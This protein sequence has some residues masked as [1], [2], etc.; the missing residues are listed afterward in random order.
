MCFHFLNPSAQNDDE[1]SLCRRLVA[2]RSP[3]PACN[4]YAI[5]LAVVLS[6]TLAT[7]RAPAAAFQ[8]TTT[9]VQVVTQAISSLKW[10]PPAAIPFGTALGPDQ[11]NAIAGPHGTFAYSPP[12][13][14]LLPAGTQTLSVIFTPDNPGYTIAT[15]SVPIV[16]TPPGS[17]SFSVGTS[18]PLPDG[19]VVLLPNQPST[20]GLNIV[21]LGDFHQPVTLTC[22]NP[23]ALVSCVF[24]PAVVR[25][26]TAP[27]RVA[28]TLEMNQH[29][30][31]VRR[32]SDLG[33]FVGDDR[34][35]VG[36]GST[37][38]PSV[39]SPFTSPQIQGAALLALVAFHRR[40]AAS[41]GALSPLL[42]IGVLFSLCIWALGC[43][44]HFNSNN[45]TTLTIVASSLTES[46]SVSM[47]LNI[48]K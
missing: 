47:Q 42:A 22:R 6:F 5:I 39:P 31:A 34:F 29:P 38:Q 10:S 23:P 12:S 2:R 32:G 25:P 13:G 8:D 26:T 3:G 24:S 44:F 18:S 46:R 43:G 35:S 14:A 28:L 17:S 15:L 19:E 41:L 27:V 1:H 48:V 9:Y 30:V 37:R 20:V 45:Q 21:P 4:R 11:L 7:G 16:V 40:S 33:E 36:K